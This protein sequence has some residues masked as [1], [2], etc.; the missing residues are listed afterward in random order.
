MATTAGWQIP[1]KKGLAMSLKRRKSLVPTL[2]T[3]IRADMRAPTQQL[4]AKS[5]GESF[6]AFKACDASKVAK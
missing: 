4:W 6:L 2:S 5:C 1:L 3:A